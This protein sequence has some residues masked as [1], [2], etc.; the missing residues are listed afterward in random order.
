M[1]KRVYI[2]TD[3]GATTSKIGAVWD[4]GKPVT[5]KL[6]QRS[7][8]SQHGTK[9]VVDT[10]TSAV[11]DF[12][13]E[14]SITWSQVD[15]IGLALPGS[16]K[17]YG[18]LD[19]CANLPPSF[20]GWNVLNDYSAAIAEKSGRK[21]AISIGNDGNFGG[22]AE[23][24]VVRQNGNCSV[25]MV[26]PGSGLGVAF[27]DGNGLPLDGDSLAGM[28]GG[29]M[30]APLQL[31]DI[32]PFPCGCGRTWGCIEV[33]TTISGLPYLVSEMLKN[34]PNHPL[35]KLKTITKDDIM[36][37]R[38][39][40]QEGDLLALEVFDFQAKALGYHIGN[41]VTALDPTYIVVGGGLMD[42]ENTTLNFRTRYLNILTKA[43]TT[44]FWP[45]Q[46]ERIKIVPASLGELSQAIGGALV[47]LYKSKQKSC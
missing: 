8:N 33:Y 31:L 29:H 23:A 19:R 32:K 18:I 39:L 37:L 34:H 20:E 4:N 9:A 16:F 14:N 36:P 47:A 5:T 1:E 22:V 24:E 44:Y 6:L 3:C 13:S 28:E 21:I 12:L 40:A 15:G 35:A 7:T 38:S 10:W 11:N 42:P 2:G 17:S 46:R 41:M 27:I 25:L 26:A 43:A 45:T 30:A